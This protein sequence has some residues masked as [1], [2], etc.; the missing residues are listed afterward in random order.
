MYVED[1]QSY[2]QGLSERHTDIRHGLQGRTAFFR[3]QGMGEM[4]Q[5]PNKAGD[6]LVMIERFGGRAIGEYDANKIQ[7]F[8]VIRF[9][10]LLDVPADGD[11]ETAIGTCMDEVYLI[12]LDFESR[13]R[14]DFANDSCSWLK[15]VDFGSI[16]WADYQGPIIERHYGWDLTIPFIASAPEYRELKWVNI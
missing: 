15:Y 4:T 13:M 5:L 11:F 7:Q 9:A 12:M 2:Y 8:V 14:H 6:V 3:L 1:I 10:K 16:S